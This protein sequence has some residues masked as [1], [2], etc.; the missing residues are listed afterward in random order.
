MSNYLSMAHDYIQNI[1]DKV[2]DSKLTKSLV[3]QFINPDTY[4]KLNKQ[5]EDYFI[6]EDMA[7]AI[8]Q[9]KDLSNRL[10][11][12]EGLIYNKLHGNITMRLREECDATDEHCI[13]TDNLNAIATSYSGEISFCFFTIFKYAEFC[14]KFFKVE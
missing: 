4:D 3:T 11:L 2:K 1:F 13:E 6:R 12:M 5:L 9:Q 14:D 8:S 7:Q 10:I